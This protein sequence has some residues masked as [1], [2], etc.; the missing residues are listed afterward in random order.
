[1][2][3]RGDA[4][5]VFVSYSHKDTRYLEDDSLLGFLKGL[6]DDHVEFWTDRHIRVGESWDEV[7][8]TQIQGAHIGLVLVSQSFLDSKYCKNVEIRRFLA[9]KSY[10]FPGAFT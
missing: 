7:I 4:I 9:N 2:P 1:M 3:I 6:E 10:L 5:K 8:K